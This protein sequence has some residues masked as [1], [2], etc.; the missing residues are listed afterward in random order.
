MDNTNDKKTVDLVLDDHRK[1]GEE[2]TEKALEDLRTYMDAKRSIDYKATENQQWWRLRHWSVIAGQTN[3]AEKAGIEVGSAWAINS[4]L[5]K[6]A[7]IM[8]SFPKPN[9]LPRE[10]DDENEAKL[11]TDILPAILDQND[12]EAVFRQGVQKRFVRRAGN[13]GGAQKKRRSH[14]DGANTNCRRINKI[15]RR[16][17]KFGSNTRN[18]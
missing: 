18:A 1:F 3:E 5:N 9:V 15:G 12:Y 7:A 8:D 16:I 11:L 10:A 6:H 17:H 4:L 14:H 13:F 2:Q